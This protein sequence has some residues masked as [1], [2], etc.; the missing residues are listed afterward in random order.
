M[1][2][3]F[4]INHS[5]Y[6]M[7]FLFTYKYLISPKLIK[8]ENKRNRIRNRKLTFDFI[9]DKLN[10][11]NELLIVETGCMRSDH[12]DLAFGDDGCSTLIFDLFAKSCEGKNYSVDISQSNIEH[13]KKFCKNTTFTQMDSVEFLEGFPLKNKIDLLYLDSYDFDILNPAPS[14]QHHLNEIMALYEEL[15][16]GCF[17]LIDDSDAKADGSVYGK[18]FLIKDFFDKK[19]L[20]PLI[21]D[22]QLLYIK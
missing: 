4:I 11:R 7:S 3:D 19:G 14:Q 20:T 17:I 12:G 15:K 13:A 6:K 22:Y 10:K 16:E 18:S 8:P 9:V 21:S 2:S 5:K 1:Y